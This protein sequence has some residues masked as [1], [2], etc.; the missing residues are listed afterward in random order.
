MVSIWISVSFIIRQYLEMPMCWR[1]MTGEVSPS[2]YF[3]YHVWP[4]ALR[5]PSVSGRRRR[6]CV[7]RTFGTV[8][9]VVSVLFCAVYTS[10]W[11]WTQANLRFFCI[12]FAFILFRSFCW[13][14]R[15]VTFIS[16]ACAFGR[17]L[18]CMWCRTLHVYCT[19]RDFP[20]EAFLSVPVLSHI[21]CYYYLYCVR[22]L[23]PPFIFLVL[24][25]IQLLFGWM[26]ASSNSRIVSE[27]YLLNH[28]NITGV[29]RA[30]CCVITR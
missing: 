7:S 24:L 29:S 5:F 20:R 9:R 11:P 23:L 22:G 4:H 3:H 12:F 18:F 1:T 2:P 10:A 8:C 21:L 14:V 30:K 16:L 26:R 28:L 27:N 13:G 17:L 25:Y 6:P 15:I 19:R